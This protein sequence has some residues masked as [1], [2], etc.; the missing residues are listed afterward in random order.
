MGCDFKKIEEKWQKKWDEIQPFKAFNFSKKPK[1]YALIEFPY[2]SGQGLHVGHP[3]SY[4]AMDIIARKRRMQGYN[5]LFPIGWDAFG[6][7]AE[8]FAI[9]NK[10]HPK[11][12]TKKNISKFK[13][14]I[15]SLGISFDWNREVNTTDPGYYKW[16]QWIFSRLFEKGLAIKEETAVNWC[17]SCKCVLANEEVIEGK[18]ERCGSG[19]FQKRK[20]QWILKI[21]K[22]AQRLIDD[23][24]TVDYPERVKQQ[25][26]NWIGRSEGALIRF[27]TTSSD[28]IL[29]VF[30]TRP[31]TIFGV[32]YMVVAPEHK[33]IESNTK[34]IEN[35][36]EINKYKTE[37]S[38][39]SEFQR[40][41]ML[42]E[43]TGVEIK[44]IR[45]INP[46]NGKE[47]PIFMADYVLIGYGTGAIMAV[48]AHDERDWEFA[49]KYSLPKPVVILGGKDGEA[50]IGDG[51]LV[52]SDFLNG[53]DTSKAK[54]K[55]IKFLEQNK[56]GESKVSFKLRDWIFSRQ[57]YWGEPI[58]IINCK[59]CG[60]VLD[61]N[62]P[63]ILPETEEYETSEDGESP[64]ANLP[65]IH[66]NCPK[67]LG[68]ALRETDTMPQWAGSS[69]YF[70]RY[71]DNEN[72]S[73]L[74]SKKAIDYWFPVDWYNGGMEHTT[75]HLLYSRFWHKF[76][77]DI[78]VVS[79]PEPYAKRTSH[80][81]ILGENGE[82]MSKSRGNVVNPDEIIQ[83]FG[84][85]AFRLYEM[86]IGDF[87]KAAP[88]SASGIR[89]CK[90][91][92]EK[93]WDMAFN[94]SDGEIRPDFQ[95]LINKTIKKVGED[96]EKLK[97][98]TAI[99]S[100]MDLLGQ[101]KK[102]GKITRDELEVFL[103][104]ISPFAP[105]VSEEIWKRSNFEG[106]ASESVWPSYNEKLI[107]L[108]Q[109]TIVLQ[110]NGK[111]RSKMVADSQISGKELI[112]L[113]KKD[114]K[115]SSI[116]KNQNIIREICV[117]SK[118]VNFVIE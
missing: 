14:Q 116:I 18:C 66:V 70:L 104:L 69:W 83:E 16:T 33:I 50:F 36:E 84:A 47:I 46:A 30:T 42:K 68:K 98:N 8:N 11:L 39:K 64:L 29:E 55:I 81:M 54:T 59:R 23:L 90:R 114:E 12:V 27:K 53:L 51:T 17:T 113:A 89:G 97:F 62:L 99:A 103:V 73:E 26:I 87:E 106:L 91:F 3:R 15:K 4:I 20:F 77:Y 80:G 79:M 112:D 32:S 74:A 37:A 2:P 24:K 96:I 88:W 48:P 72:D 40:S 10:I 5:V 63:L 94:I 35:M 65:W 13:E 38:K 57:R 118:L 58:P 43:K 71:S 101:I 115:I 82:K 105:H 75:L 93:F 1:F 49:I 86:F 92:L 25:Q 7:P 76:L 60:L 102:T 19:I 100:L 111:I 21:T 108:E 78:G 6:L 31:E 34:L 85:D 110:I 45:A 67:C 28:Q 9:K 22:Y 117:P 109:N 52:N 44:G 56:N 41:Q 107:K 61:K 95:T